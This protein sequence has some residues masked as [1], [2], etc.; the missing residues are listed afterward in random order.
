MAGPALPSIDYYFRKERLSDD[1][2]ERAHARIVGDLT[3]AK[4]GGLICDFRVI[5]HAEAFPTPADESAVLKR[6]REFS[7]VKKVGLGRQFGSNKYHFS[8]FPSHALLVSVGSELRNVFP[9]ELENGRVEALNDDGEK[10]RQVLLLDSVS[11]V[12]YRSRLI[13]TLEALRT[14]DA[15]L[16]REYMGFPENLPNLRA[17]QAPAN[18]KPDGIVNCYF[19]LRE[20]GELP[21][22]Y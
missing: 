15:G 22:T 6:L 5:E 17:K 14:N 9:C 13:R 4:A 8:L 18:T 12:R 10:L 19:A 7:M 11:N 16:Y 2:G 21:A 1:G 3:E 20:R